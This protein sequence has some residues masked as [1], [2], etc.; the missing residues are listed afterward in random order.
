MFG[1]TNA[2]AVMLVLALSACAGLPQSKLISTASGTHEYVAAGQGRPVVVLEAGLGDGLESWSSVFHDVAQITRVFGY[3]RAE[4]GKSRST[5]RRRDAATTVGEL[6][7][8]LRASNMLPPYVLVGHS[9]GGT[10]MEYYAR[11]YPDEVAGVVLVDSRH[12]GFTRKCKVA[13]ASFC[14]PPAFLALL[15]PAAAKRELEAADLTMQQVIESPEFPPVPLVVLTGMSKPVEGE[16]FRQVWLETQ[17]DLAK[18]SPVSKHVV[19]QRCGHYVHHD[20]AAAVVDAVRWLVET[21]RE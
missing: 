5:N 12:A 7:A 15:L 14:D 21:V 11:A 19:C 3:D 20:N 16:R 18:L 13:S 8:L 10:Y 6:R 2:L 4:Y 1:M 9:I 17:K